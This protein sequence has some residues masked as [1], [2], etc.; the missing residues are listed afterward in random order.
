MIVSGVFLHIAPVEGLLANLNKN[1]IIAQQ[2][3]IVQDSAE[4]TL[5]NI[6]DEYDMKPIDIMKIINPDKTG[7]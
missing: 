7:K 5:K 2:D 3:K 6:A 4:M 1:N